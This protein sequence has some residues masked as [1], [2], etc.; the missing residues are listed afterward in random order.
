MDT[1]AGPLV[2]R[3]RA[4]GC[5]FAEDEA[6]LLL[7]AGGDLDA[8]VERRVAGEPL[9]QVLG[10]AEFCGLRFAVEPGVFVPR[11]RSRLLVREAVRRAAARSVVLD[12]C[13]GTGAVG[14][15]VA[16][17]VPGVEL[18]AAD[19][20]P[21]AVRCARRNVPGTVYGGD[22]YA[23]LPG[24]L[25]GRVDVLVCN[26]PYVPTEAIALMPPEARDHELRA[27]LDGGADG[28]DVQRRVAAGAP[29]WLAP[30]GWLLVETSDR[31]APVTLAAF[32][33]AGLRA[34]VVA[35]EELAATIVVGQLLSCC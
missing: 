21:A 7:E 25:R 8:L 16:D 6:A 30:G 15:A 19:V 17:A 1:D 32:A 9:E 23:A 12:L 31:Q 18:H 5:V 22:L 2:A 33:A 24:Q 34:E 20:D 28:V 3:L 26:A 13:C 29:E 35:D 11:Q 10:W 27:A 14:A 4:A